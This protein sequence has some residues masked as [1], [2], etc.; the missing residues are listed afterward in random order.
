MTLE[1]DGLI[2]CVTL[3]PGADEP[4]PVPGDYVHLDF[5]I[6]SVNGAESWTSTT[7][8]V[9]RIGASPSAIP[10]IELM[11][12]RMTTGARVEMVVPPDL[13]YGERGYPP[14]V[15]ANSPVRIILTLVDITRANHD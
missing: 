4:L 15:P 13:G 3:A 10:A 12:P 11:A 9:L 2:S 1:I 14:I 6:S 8:F 7:P 5:I